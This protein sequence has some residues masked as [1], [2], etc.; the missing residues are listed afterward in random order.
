MTG[1]EHRYSFQV[2]FSECDPQ[3]VVYYANYLTYMDHAV[4][5]YLADRGID[6]DAY[7]AESGADFHVVNAQIS[8]RAPLRPHDCFELGV[9]TARVGG[10]SVTFACAVLRSDAEEPLA[11]GEVVWVHTDQ[12]TRRPTTVPDRLRALLTA[13]TG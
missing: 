13:P 9:R 2:R 10:S 7:V 5:A 11:A 4:Y 8:Y 3:G 12:A 1:F 6:V